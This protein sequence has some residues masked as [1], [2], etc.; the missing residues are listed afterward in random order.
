MVEPRLSLWG[1]AAGSRLSAIGGSSGAPPPGHGPRPSE[2]GLGDYA[3]S[4]RP[5][6]HPDWRPLFAAQLQE[7]TP[8]AASR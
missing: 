4:S 6:P 5:A 2:A 3:K 7:T 1:R 8:A